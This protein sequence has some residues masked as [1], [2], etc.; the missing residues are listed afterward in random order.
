MKSYSPKL[1]RA[2][3]AAAR[4]RSAISNVLVQAG[5]RACRRKG[6]VLGWHFV[7]SERNQIRLVTTSA[8]R[9][10]H[11]ARAFVPTFMCSNLP[12]SWI[13]APTH[14]VYL[15]CRNSSA[16]TAITNI[17]APTAQPHNTLFHTS[18]TS[19]C[20]RHK[21]TGI[22]LVWSPASRDRVQDSTRELVVAMGNHVEVPLRPRH[23]GHGNRSFS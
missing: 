17:R 14:T 22:T 15:L 3:T 23:T 10:P 2:G 7:G 11:D 20:S 4:I 18:L 13:V 5:W 1:L 8:G 21:D 12:K 19:F 9:G 16:P 6:G